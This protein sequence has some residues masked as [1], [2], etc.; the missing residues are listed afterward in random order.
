MYVSTAKSLILNIHNCS[1]ING[2]VV[3]VGCNVFVPWHF[4]EAAAK[5]LTIDALDPEAKNPEF[6]VCAVQVF[7]A[8]EDELANPDVVVER[9]RY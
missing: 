7:P 9:G 6:K 2:I 1:F 4:A 8:R 3:P 5:L